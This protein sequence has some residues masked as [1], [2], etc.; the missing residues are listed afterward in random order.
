MTHHHTHDH[1]S[2]HSS[3]VKTLFWCFWVITTFMVIE[4]VA[5]KWFDSLALVADAGHMAND[6]FALALS[7]LSLLL[8]K[9]AKKLSWWL[10]VINAMS[11]LVIAVFVIIKAIYRLQNPVSIDAVPMM[12]VAAIGLFVN[13]FVAYQMLNANQ[14][15]INV[16]LAY[17]HVLVDLLGSVVAMVAGLVIYLFGWLWIDGVASLVLGVFV[18][19]SGCAALLALI[20]K[21]KG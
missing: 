4:F 15:N 12:L 3:D 6:A 13:V 11:L 1:H 2:H 8:A 19:R 14:Q 20:N 9:H 18:L 7:L 17:L 21:N 5:G 10:S 16:R